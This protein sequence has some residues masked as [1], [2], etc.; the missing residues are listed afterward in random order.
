MS[1]LNKIVDDLSKLSVMEAA[2]LSKLLQEK[3]RQQDDSL[4]WLAALISDTG[5]RLAEAVGLSKNDLKLTEEVPHVVITKHPWRPLK[6][7]GSQRVIPLVE[8]LS[9]DFSEA[10]RHCFRGVFIPSIR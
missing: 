1:D 5:M 9:M 10:L 6:T 7:S 3:C 2:E 4:R 8:H